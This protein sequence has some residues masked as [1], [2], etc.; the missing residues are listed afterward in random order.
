MEPA[1][2]VILM[3][4]SILW[5]SLHTSAMDGYARFAAKLKSRSLGKSSEPFLNSVV[6]EFV[7][8]VLKCLRFLYV[9][10]YAMDEFIILAV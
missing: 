5:G 2:I 3:Q 10:Y 1:F 6:H 4:L 9:Q 7:I 8:R